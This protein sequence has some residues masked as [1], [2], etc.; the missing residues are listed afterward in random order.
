ML[1]EQPIFVVGAPRS[2]TTLLRLMLDCHPRI[3][4][5]D[6]SHFVV[7]LAARRLRLR[8]RPAVALERILVHRRFRHWQLDEAAVRAAFAARQ[9]A[10]F[11]DVVRVVFECEAAAHG[12]A[13]WGDKTPTY[14]A[15]ISLLA[16]LFPDAMFLH[17]IRDGRE[18]AASMAERG[19]GRP[20]AVS[21][22]YWWRRLVRT[23]RAAGHALGPD[24]YLEVRHEAL[25]ANPGHQ[26]RTVCAFLGED[27]DDAMLRYPEAAAVRVRRGTGDLVARPD[28][29][30]LLLPPTPGLRDW[31]AGLSPAVQAQVE[32]ACGPML[33]TLGYAAHPQP[34]PVHAAARAVWARDLV[35][36]APQAV[37]LRL[38]PA[39]AGQE[40]GLAG[41]P[42]GKRRGP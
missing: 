9:P 18:V 1:S 4:I 20:S 11:A 32:A 35:S 10:T 13:R 26:L 41:R 19:W 22:A 16:R 21:A 25:A 29:A 12:K 5:P 33:R 34:P 7:G 15:D 14:V 27:Y 24:R 37:L 8:N 30:G 6:E 39:R 42:L 38:S 23:G 31:R 28:K 3:S 2:G 36:L 40:R 17:I